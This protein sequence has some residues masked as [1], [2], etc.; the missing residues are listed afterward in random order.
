MDDK[1]ISGIVG[2]VLAITGVAVLALIVSNQSNTSAVLTGAGTS[3]SNV[4]TTALS[5]VTG[6]SNGLGG[7]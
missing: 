6:G 5:P 7:L 3:F 2:V 4:L 1:L